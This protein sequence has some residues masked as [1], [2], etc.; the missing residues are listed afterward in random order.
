[1]R[2]IKTYRKVGAFYIAC[3]EDLSIPIRCGL[4]GGSSPKVPD[5]SFE[6]LLLVRAIDDLLRTFRDS[7]IRRYGEERGIGL[8]AH[9]VGEL[10]SLFAHAWVAALA[11]YDRFEVGRG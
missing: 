7:E 9:D 6:H 8:G 2:T 5:S 10:K 11:R 1:M 4:P 3:A